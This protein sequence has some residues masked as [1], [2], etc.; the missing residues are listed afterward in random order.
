MAEN[1]GKHDLE[2]IAALCRDYATARARLGEKAERIRAA[3]RRAA[4]S[5]M[6]VLRERVAEALV[7][8]ERLRVAL[9]ESPELFRA[10]RT[11]AFEGV[12]VGYRKQPGRL[13][14]DEA[15]TIDLIRRR[16]PERQD[17]LIR[18]SARLVRA[19]LKNL[20]SHLLARVGARVVEV[21][22]QIVLEAAPDELDDLIN[23]LLADE[24]DAR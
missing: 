4:K 2:Q 24:E 12:K 16:L 23:A 21:D 10:P 9:E 13:E 19:A 5:H 1:K 20:D 7:A 18:I 17:D 15:R 14:C 22:D 11:R 3:R 6:P 8:K